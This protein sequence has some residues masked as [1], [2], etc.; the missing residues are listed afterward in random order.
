[1]DHDDA[2][3][4]CGGKGYHQTFLGAS[5]CRKCGGEGVLTLEERE[6]YW[7]EVRAQERLDER[8]GR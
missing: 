6:A 8:R 7:R 3:P 1:M 2:C 5:P 4:Y